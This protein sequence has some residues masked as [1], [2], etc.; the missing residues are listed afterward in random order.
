MVAWEGEGGKALREVFLHPRG[1]FWGGGGMGGDDFL[2]AGLSGEPIGAIENG[3]D[4][5]GDGG[6]LVQARHMRLGILLEMELA[7]LPGDARKD[8]LAGG[9]EAFVVIT[10]DQPWGMETAL[11]ETGEKGAPMDLRFAQGD[12]DAQDAAFA[13]GAD[14]QS[15]EHGTIENLPPLP[16]FFIAGVDEDIAAGF[17]WPGTPAFQ[18]GVEPGSA[19]ADLGGADRLAAELFDDGRDFAGGNALHIHFG[20]GQFEG[21]FAADALLEGGGIEVQIAAHL[22]DLELNGTAAGDEG[23]GLETIG[24]AQAGVGA[25]VGLRWNAN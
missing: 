10:D 18:L 1:E 25:F 22:R 3:A 21:L 4:G 5:V 8:R 16:D 13:I 14:A 9:P 15:N 24:V 11:L 12:A 7:A 20:Q 17:D 19:L 6:A 23:F 2:E